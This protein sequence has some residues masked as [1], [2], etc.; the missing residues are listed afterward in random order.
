MPG[1]SGKI[2]LEASPP[3]I[4][5]AFSITDIKTGVGIQADI[6]TPQTAV[7]VTKLKTF[8]S[9]K[10]KLKK[11]VKSRTKKSNW[12]TPVTV[13]PMN[14]FQNTQKLKEKMRQSYLDQFR[15]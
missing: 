2:Y 3:P 10:M 13:P 11:R 9:Q 8:T 14:V 15:P 6:A 5:Q 7:A 4:V 12:V 1:V